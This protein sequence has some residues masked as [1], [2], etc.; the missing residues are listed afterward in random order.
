MGR[1][2]ITTDYHVVGGVSY[3]GHNRHHSGE[4]HEIRID[5]TGPLVNI[6]KEEF[7]R[8]KQD[9]KFEFKIKTIYDLF[10]FKYLLA[11]TNVMALGDTGFLWVV[12]KD[13]MWNRLND[14]AEHSAKSLVRELIVCNKAFKSDAVIGTIAGQLMK[15]ERFYKSMDSIP[16]RCKVV[17]HSFSTGSCRLHYKYAIPSEVWSEIKTGIEGMDYESIIKPSLSK[18]EEEY[19]NVLNEIKFLEILKQQ[20]VDVNNRMKREDCERFSDVIKQL[21]SDGL[22]KTP[23]TGDIK[24]KPD[25]TPTSGGDE[26]PPIPIINH[27]AKKKDAIKVFLGDNRFWEPGSFLNGHFILIGGSGAGKTE[28]EKQGASQ[29]K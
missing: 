24:P 9:L 3:C 19:G 22:I 6:A 15:E 12:T 2:R 27:N 23:P 21:N 18:L 5:I 16:E 20:K 7:E 26:T 17:E 11:D 29:K 8:K 14:S 4:V 10:F 25:V 13:G 1:E 28:T